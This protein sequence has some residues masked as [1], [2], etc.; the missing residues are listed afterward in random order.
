VR[1]S[2]NPCS[3]LSRLGPD[4]RGFTL[5]ELLVVIAIIALLIGILLPSLGSARQTA[6]TIKCGARMRSVAQGVAVY[7]TTSR[8]FPPHYVY[9]ADETTQEWRIADQAITNPTPGNGYVHWSYSLM[10]DGSAAEDAF[11]CPTLPNGGAPAT[12]PGPNPKDW[13]EEQQ[14]DLGN[15]LG[16]NTPNDRQV[17]RTAF[18]GNAAVFPRNKFSDVLGTQR[19]NQFVKDSDI[20][21]TDRTI[22][23]T[24]FY[25]S[26][27]WKA[28]RTG[29]NVIKS[30]RPI[31][32]FVGISAGGDPYSEPT[33]GSVAR[34]RYN[35]ENE[36]YNDAD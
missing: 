2:T 13:E 19:K 31:T 30:H 29:N 5:I 8:Y 12:N 27:R 24:E 9:G 3:I 10:S 28:L 18:T 35:T 16:A 36:I 17:K 15:G 32:P 34:F 26:D 1:V 14:N 11:K 33:G 21:F 25:Y 7:Q 6:R 23:L 4:R 22:L 20:E